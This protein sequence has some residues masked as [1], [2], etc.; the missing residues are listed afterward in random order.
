MLGSLVT[1]IGTKYI[2]IVLK[3]FIPCLGF[4]KKSNFTIT[5]LKRP[6]SPFQSIFFKDHLFHTIPH[7]VWRDICLELFMCFPFWLP[8]LCVQLSSLRKGSNTLKQSCEEEQDEV[9]VPDT[10]FTLRYFYF[11]N[12]FRN[13][14]TFFFVFCFSGQRSKIESDSVRFIH[15]NILNKSQSRFRNGSYLVCSALVA[16]FWSLFWLHFFVLLK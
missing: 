15:V 1:L 12:G 14:F 6:M 2:Y 10:S 5:K 4:E 11:K 16:W 7:A 13:P 9:Q 8:V 3:R